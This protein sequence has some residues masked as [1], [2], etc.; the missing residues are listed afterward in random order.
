MADRKTRLRTRK[1]NGEVEVLVLINH[2]ME[3]GRRI[4]RRTKEKIPP[5][6]IQKVIV[7]HNGRV[8]ASASLG[9]GVSV[10]PLLGFHL[11]GGKNGDPLKISW[12]DNLGESGSIANV[13]DVR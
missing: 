10:N 7:E 6:F 2:P 5:H 13:V 8:V 1:R 9:V 12:S 11:K 3:T 4:D